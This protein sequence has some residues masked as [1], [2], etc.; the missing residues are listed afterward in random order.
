M[1]PKFDCRDFYDYEYFE[2][3]FPKFPPEI[4]EKLVDIQR[5]RVVFVSNK[6]EK[7]R[8]NMKKSE[9]GNYVL[10]FD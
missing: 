7:T 6:D 10:Y 8:S 4:I 5:E 9:N 2:S 3:K 1:D